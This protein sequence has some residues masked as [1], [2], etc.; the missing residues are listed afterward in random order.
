MWMM[1]FVFR[2]LLRKYN[3]QVPYKSVQD[4]MDPTIWK[5]FCFEIYHM[6]NR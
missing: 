2:D 6:K 1:L 3:I 4:S 5:L